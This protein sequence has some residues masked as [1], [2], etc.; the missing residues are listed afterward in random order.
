MKGQADAAAAVAALLTREGHLAEEKVAPLC[1]APPSPERQRNWALDGVAEGAR[2]RG[3][4]PERR[5]PGS[6]S[7]DH[8]AGRQPGGRRKVLGGVDC[9]L[10]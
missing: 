1:S 8:T 10:C 9:G 4:A 6:G 7:G 5:I 3:Y 2:G